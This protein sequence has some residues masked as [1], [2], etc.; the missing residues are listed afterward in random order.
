MAL[1]RGEHGRRGC[2]GWGPSGKGSMLPSDLFSTKKGKK[3]HPLPW[4]G[5]MA[6]PHSGGTIPSKAIYMARAIF[7]NLHSNSSSKFR[8]K[9]I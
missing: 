4:S 8:E 3:D 1:G 9:S 5:A 2:G 7:L 6:S